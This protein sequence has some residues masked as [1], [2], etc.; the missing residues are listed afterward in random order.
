MKMEIIRE[1][2]MATK[3]YLRMRATD[4][5]D[6]YAQTYL[7]DYLHKVLLR[8]NILTL[9]DLLQYRWQNRPL[10][11]IQIHAVK[12][13]EPNEVRADQDPELPPLH[14]ALLPVA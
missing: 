3:M 10:V 13:A 7:D 14:L 4:T 6:V 12:L 8:N 5:D 9:H 11:H 2:L 1:D